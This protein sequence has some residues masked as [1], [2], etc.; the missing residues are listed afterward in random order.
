MLSP[1]EQRKQRRDEWIEFTAGA[2][3]LLGVILLCLP[4]EWWA[5][6]WRWLP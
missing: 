2:L 1:A 5:A 6:I 3:A 4:S